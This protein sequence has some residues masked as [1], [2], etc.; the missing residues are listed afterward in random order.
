MCGIYGITAKDEAFINKY[1]DIC[2]HRGPDGRGVWSDNFVTLGHNLLAI[3]EHSTQSQQPWTTPRGNILIY[4]GEI[5]NYYELC[6]K[7]TDFVPKTECDTELLA[8][9]LDTHGPAFIDLID[10]MH[11]FAYYDLQDKKL[12][13]SRDHAGIKPLHYAEIAEGIVFGSEIKGM[14]DRVPNSRTVD[15]MALS[16]FSL[17]GVNVTKHTFFTGIKKLLPGETLEY[18]IHTKTLTRLKRITIWPNADKT[19]DLEEFRSKM[20]DSVK[21]CAIGK[22]QIGVFLSGGIDSTMVAYELNKVQ[23]PAWTFT[24]YINPCPKADE[25]FNSD[26]HAAMVLAQENNFNHTQIEITPDIYHAHWEDAV[27]QIEQPVYSSN[28]PMYTYT[29]K[30]MHERGVVVTMAGDMGDEL[31]A[32]YPKYYRIPK[33][34]THRQTVE[35]WLRRIKRPM[36]LPD[37][38]YSLGQV[39]DEL[40]ATIF[41]SQLFNSADPVASYMTMDQIGLCPEEFFSRNDRY[42]MAYKMEGRFPLATKKFM[43]YCAN[44]KTSVKMG[45][46]EYDTKVL[47]RRAYRGHMPDAVVNKEKTGWTAPALFWRKQNMDKDLMKSV[48]DDM[49]SNANHNIKGLQQGAKSMIPGMITNLWATKYNMRT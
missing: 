45:N 26:Q 23:S 43:Q 17:A 2:S 3:T 41:P 22:R 16:C 27:T 49:F 44:I 40:C 19:C 35:L 48:Y 12:L 32:G 38:T 10:S 8:W 9:G 42:G 25:N 11:A 33:K 14:L 46:G 29:N 31:F 6:A 37:A 13:L 7:F 18:S 4:N 5:F 47:P 21:M 24:N 28:L 34:L 30:F 15:K 1:I 20:H 39:A 36:N